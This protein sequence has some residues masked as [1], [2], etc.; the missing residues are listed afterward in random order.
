MIRIDM[1]MIEEVSETNQKSSPR[2]SNF[3][4]PFDKLPMSSEFSIAVVEEQMQ[5][6]DHID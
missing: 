3:P 6:E 2:K 1:D 4:V 5:S